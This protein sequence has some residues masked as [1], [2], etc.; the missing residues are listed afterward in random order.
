MPAMESNR[1]NAAKLA[2]AVVMFGAAGVLVWRFLGDHG[3]VSEKA[4]FYDLSERK[5]F[6]AERGLIPPI[7]GVNDATEDGVRAVVISTNGH[8]QDKTTW[9]IAY[10]ETCSPELKQQLTAARAAGT[11]PA[12][13]RTAAQ[14][15]RLV[16]RPGDAAWVSLSSPEGERIVTDW[17]A[18]GGGEGAPVVCSP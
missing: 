15:Q 16:Q 17:A 13:S 12:I 18:S 8:P 11:A 4:F 5:L 1:S 6:V 7:R 14:A 9:T 10:L 3:G 2:G